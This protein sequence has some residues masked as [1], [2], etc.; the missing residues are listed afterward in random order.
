MD[1]AATRPLPA[2]FKT[3]K[4][5]V[6]RGGESADPGIINAGVCGGEG[7]GNAFSFNSAVLWKKNVA[8]IV[9]KKRGPYCL[10]SPVSSTMP[11]VPGFHP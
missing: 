8:P 7:G 1:R 9:E 4:I 5:D 3:P 11:S 10:S 6:F 2:L